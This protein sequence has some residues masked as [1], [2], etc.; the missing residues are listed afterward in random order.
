MQ[1]SDKFSL[2]CINLLMALSS[3][4]LVQANSSHYYELLCTVLKECSVFL[5]VWAI[6]GYPL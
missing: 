2:H 4:P 5:R 6:F 3:L 1:K